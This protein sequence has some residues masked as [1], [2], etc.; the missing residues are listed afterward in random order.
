MIL[1]VDWSRLCG[2]PLDSARKLSC[3]CGQLAAGAEVLLRPLGRIIQDGLVTPRTEASIL[4]VASYPPQQGSQTCYTLASL[5]GHKDAR[6]QAFLRL[7]T[8]T[9]TVTSAPPMWVKGQPKFR[10]GGTPQGHKYQEAIFGAH[11]RRTMR[12]IMN[13][14]VT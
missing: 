12:F 10:M 4:C 13:L 5:Q 6:C 7:S 3:S 11:W 2:S 8:K 9:G 1:C 14:Y